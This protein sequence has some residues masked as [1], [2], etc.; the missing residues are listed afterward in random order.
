[1]TEHVPSTAS[2]AEEGLRGPLPAHAGVTG[3]VKLLILLGLLVSIM[4][5]LFVAFAAAPVFKLDDPAPF[6]RVWPAADSAKIDLP[7]SKF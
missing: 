4:Q 1:M 7:P 2:S 6:G 5:G 3:G